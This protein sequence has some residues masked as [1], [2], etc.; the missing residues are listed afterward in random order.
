LP[1]D[2]YILDSNKK[3]KE[4]QPHGMLS[5]ENF[6]CHECHYVKAKISWMMELMPDNPGPGDDD[7]SLFTGKVL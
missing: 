1:P 3:K 5:L 7:L 2:F 6:A 4:S